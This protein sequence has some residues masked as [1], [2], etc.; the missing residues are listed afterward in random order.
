[1]NKNN[2]LKTL[3][4]NMLYAYVSQAVSTLIGLSFTIL[5]PKV[6]G[7]SGY[8]YWQLIVFYT[9]YLGVF[10]LGIN[11]GIYLRNGG[12][13]FNEINKTVIAKIGKCFFGIHSLV[14]IVIAICAFFF[15][16]DHNRIFV[17]VTTACYLP[18]FN[19]KGM[20]GQVMQAVNN[21]K[22]SSVANL[23]DRIV[24]FIAVFICLGLHIT[25]FRYYVVFYVVGGFCATLYCCFRA[26]EIFSPRL[27]SDVK[28]L[29]EIK[30]DIKAGFPLMI[31]SFSA[32]MITGISRQIIDMRWEISAFSK[33][34][35]ALTMMNL[36]LVFLNQ[37]SLVLFP[38]IRKI[39]QSLQ[40]E[41]YTSFNRLI[42]II[43]P[44]VLVFYVPIGKL[45][46]MWLPEYYESII[47]LGILLPICIWDGKMNLLNNTYYKVLRMERQL[48]AINI[49]TL[50]LNTLF[51]I[52]GA[53]I[54]GNINLIAYGLLVSIACRSLVSE[55]F[56]QKRLKK[57][58][59][60]SVCIPII[61][62]VLYITFNN[63]L[64]EWWAFVAYAVLYGI[65][66]AFTKK[67]I[68]LSY[69][70]LKAVIKKQ[71]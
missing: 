35:L 64:P 5:I 15:V 48:L 62:S 70:N 22:V 25:D 41:L 39:E 71:I 28:I 57:K 30:E 10:Y 58:F 8:G 4:S 9:T 40:V 45:I 11:D 34:S 46:N 59:D 61:G 16:A 33:I 43:V 32:L 1:M 47:F 53:Y 24:T 49:G 27:D 20:L 65:I 29:E 36:V 23:I 52:A 7:V 14:G 63:T 26:R 55:V 37:S 3:T 21:T 60:F 51:S 31:S 69:K 2:F 68:K 54:F 44:A 50:I 13:E 12:K 42:N 67:N 6:L 66:F 18:L 38:A 19:I 56:L 17:L